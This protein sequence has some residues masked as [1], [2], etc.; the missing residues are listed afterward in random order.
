MKKICAVMLLLALIALTG[1][2]AAQGSKYDV[3]KVHSHIGF[4]VT[5]LVISKVH[6]EFKDYEIDL[7]YN[8]KDVTK[9]TVEV[10]I[11]VTSIDTDNQKRDDHLRSSDFFDAANNPE[12]IFKSKKIEKSDN[13]YVAHGDLTIRGVT[14][15]VALP[16]KVN[17]PVKDPW[18]N[19]RIGIEANLTINRHDYGVSWNKALD[20]GGFVVGD[21]V[22]IGIQTS[23]IASQT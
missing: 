9:T 5:H 13:G 22:E 3:D 21:E 4:D 14:K 2:T 20:G 11:K 16:F 19:T 18:G 8:E 7:L 12:I 17:G 6:G 23:L 10:R 1:V 15:E